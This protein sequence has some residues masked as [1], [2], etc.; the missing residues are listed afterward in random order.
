VWR[1]TNPR[2][3]TFK[4]LGEVIKTAVHKTAKT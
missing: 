3:E 1:R 4:A 2:E